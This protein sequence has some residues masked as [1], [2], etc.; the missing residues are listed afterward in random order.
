MSQPAEPLVLVAVGVFF[1]FWIAIVVGWVRIAT[2]TGFI[3]AGVMALGILVRIISNLGGF[4]Q[5]LGVG[6]LFLI[7]CNVISFFGRS[8]PLYYQGPEITLL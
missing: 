7:V 2:L 8:A 3:I 1:L 4:L 6:A 5:I